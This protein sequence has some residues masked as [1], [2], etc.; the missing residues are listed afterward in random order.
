MA[1][2]YTDRK[3]SKVVSADPSTVRVGTLIF[4]DLDGMIRPFDV[5]E[6]TDYAGTDY[7]ELVASIAR[8][9]ILEPVQVFNPSDKLLDALVGNQERGIP[10][11]S[12]SGADGETYN[13]TDLESALVLS[14]G[15]RRVRALAEAHNAAPDKVRAVVP[16]LVVE[17]P[18]PKEAIGVLVAYNVGRKNM[19]PRA[20]MDA[21]N[22]AVGLTGAKKVAN[23]FVK[24][25]LGCGIAHAGRMVA[26]YHMQAIDGSD[27]ILDLLLEDTVTRASASAVRKAVDKWG[28]ADVLATLRG[29]VESGNGSDSKKVNSA[30]NALDLPEPSDD[31]V[32]GDDDDEVSGAREKAPREPV[33]ESHRE[34]RLSIMESYGVGIKPTEGK[35]SATPDGVMLRDAYA[36]RYVRL[37]SVFA[38]VPA[39]KMADTIAAYAIGLLPE[40][41]EDAGL[42]WNGLDD[43]GR[44]MVTEKAWTAHLKAAQAAREEAAKKDAASKPK[45]GKVSKGSKADANASAD[46]T[47]ARKAKKDGKCAC[48]H[49][50]FSTAI[51]EGEVDECLACGGREQVT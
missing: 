14:S 1:T 39:L 28:C 31:D 5:R 9:G 18:S 50:R 12:F 26:M 30:L 40:G 37:M 2:Y 51:G 34:I 44:D 4:L 24:A 19:S 46:A 16:A 48:E 27:P 33:P 7:E 23:G 21:L 49:P 41:C 42:L 13:R 8:R 25:T 20:Q 47:K 11:K 22:L 3:Q 35:I 36:V 6:A 38:G 43:K 32:E 29:V 17:S 45:S 10:V 15:H